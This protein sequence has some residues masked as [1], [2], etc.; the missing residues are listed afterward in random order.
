MMRV[1]QDRYWTFSN[2]SESLQIAAQPGNPDEYFDLLGTGYNDWR[3]A[4]RGFA[5]I[6]SSLFDAYVDGAGISSDIEDGC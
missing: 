1:K 5:H 6:N 2:Q 3:L 4:F